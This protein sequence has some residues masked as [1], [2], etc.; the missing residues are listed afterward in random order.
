MGFAGGEVHSLPALLPLDRRCAMRKNC[1]KQEAVSLRL[2]SP[3]LA[4]SFSFI[5]SNAPLSIHRSV[6]VYPRK[7]LIMLFSLPLS[8]ALSLS[9]SVCV[10]VC[11]CVCA[12]ACVCVCVCVQVCVCVCARSCV[13]ARVCVCVTAARSCK[14]NPTA[15]E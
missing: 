9:L 15:E 13:R 4:H 8:L 14:N 11:V 5:F 7:D 12:R 3:T 1:E 10:S 6:L 2:P